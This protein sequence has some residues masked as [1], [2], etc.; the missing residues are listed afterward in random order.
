MYKQLEKNLIHC[1]SVCVCGCVCVGVCVAKCAK[2]WWLRVLLLNA[3][4]AQLFAQ[5]YAEAMQ[6]HTYL[7]DAKSALLVRPGNIID[8]KMYVGS[9]ERV[10]PR[11]CLILGI[12][13]SDTN[14]W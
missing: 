10:F 4:F 14:N 8:W 12:K 5:E 2:L 1:F 13:I 3:S 9:A 6:I 7:D 11:S